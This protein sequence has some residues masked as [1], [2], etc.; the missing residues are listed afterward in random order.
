MNSSYEIIW[1]VNL[2]KKRIILKFPKYKTVYWKSI[3][4]Y[5]SQEEETLN[6]GDVYVFKKS[7]FKWF[8]VDKTLLI[9]VCALTQV[10]GT[11]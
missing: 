3:L 1:K 10:L 7:I 11:N 9:Y 4:N 6:I 5:V 8:Y 2:K